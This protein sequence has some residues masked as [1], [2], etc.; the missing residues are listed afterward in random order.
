M[1]T[2]E[3][4]LVYAKSMNKLMTCIYR[5]T[6]FHTLDISHWSP[7]PGKAH[8][9]SEWKEQAYGKLYKFRES[10]KEWSIFV[11]AFDKRLQLLQKSGTAPFLPMSNVEHLVSIELHH[12]SFIIITMDC[13]N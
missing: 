5:R 13:D 7:L 11:S 3:E 6:Y 4:A 12:L 10:V 8:F 1:Q 2:P 9:F